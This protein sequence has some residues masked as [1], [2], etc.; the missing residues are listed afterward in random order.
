MFESISK[1]HLDFHKY[2][3]VKLLEIPLSGTGSAQ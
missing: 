1:D 2:G 3:K